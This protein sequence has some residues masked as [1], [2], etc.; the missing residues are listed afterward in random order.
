MK[1][2]LD[3]DTIY[4]VSYFGLAYSDALKDNILIWGGIIAIL[5][6]IANLIRF[7]YF[8]KDRIERITF[9]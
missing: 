9:F 6:G 5:V 1:P 3:T 4:L 8:M 2:L 7:F